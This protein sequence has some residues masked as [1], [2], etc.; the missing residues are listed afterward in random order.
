MPDDPCHYGVP[1]AQCH[2]GC[3]HFCRPGRAALSPAAT[4]LERL[5]R[6]REAER[7]N[8]CRDCGD[9]R[10]CTGLCAQ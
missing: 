6:E 9:N 10:A 2:V 3:G 8:H 7:G 4:K 5:V 1:R